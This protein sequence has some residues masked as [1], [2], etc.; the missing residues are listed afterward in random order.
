V[1]KIPLTEMLLYG[2]RMHRLLDSAN[3]INCEGEK[4]H[5]IVGGKL[6]TKTG[7]DDEFDYFLKNLK[8]GRGFYGKPKHQ[9]RITGR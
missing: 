6:S 9:Y 1:L 2:I 8:K 3:P 7:F 5:H 4:S